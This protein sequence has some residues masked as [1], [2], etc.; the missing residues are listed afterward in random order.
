MRHEQH[1]AKECKA[2][3]ALGAVYMIDILREG[4]KSDDARLRENIP[5]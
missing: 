2:S 1:F 3:L 5:E 4:W